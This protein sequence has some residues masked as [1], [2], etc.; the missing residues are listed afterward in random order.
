MTKAPIIHSAESRPGGVEA[1]PGRL[2]VQIGV[3]V[4]NTERSSKFFSLSCYLTSPQIA[5][6]ASR[7]LILSLSSY[8]IVT[9]RHPNKRTNNTG[10]RDLAGAAVAIGHCAKQGRTEMREMISILSTLSYTRDH[11]QVIQHISVKLEV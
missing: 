10:T 2:F 7:G 8:L 3:F 11:R 4:P 9:V 1:I 5:T 6:Q